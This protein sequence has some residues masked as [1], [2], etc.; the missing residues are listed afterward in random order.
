MGQWH[1][2]EMLKRVDKAWR[3]QRAA[4]LGAHLE[5]HLCGA[6]AGQFDAVLRRA[7]PARLAQLDHAAECLEVAARSE[8][9]RS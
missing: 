7:D 3:E 1:L 5:K 6:V 4:D 9:R 8:P 2:E